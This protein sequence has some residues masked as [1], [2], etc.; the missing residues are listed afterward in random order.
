MRRMHRAALLSGLIALSLGGPLSAQPPD[1]I[2]A[3]VR[4]EMTG[5]RIP[6]MAVAVI[7]RDLS[8][9]SGASEVIKAQGYGLA[10]VEHNVPVTPQTIFQSGSLGKQFTA[11][12][13]MLQVEDG[14]LSVTDSISK[15]FPNAPESWKAITVRHLL[16]HT[17]GIPY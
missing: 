4:E 7:R 2:D 11:A 16:T 3:I 5:Q 15:F 1:A 12:A 14:K 17:S 10:N 6:G 8:T 13:V 9:S